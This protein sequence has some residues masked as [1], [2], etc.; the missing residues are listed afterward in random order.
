MV[1]RSD[2]Y[3]RPLGRR[4]FLGAAAAVL[5]AACAPQRGA[6]ALAPLAA[7]PAANE[8]PD[9]FWRATPEV[10]EAYRYALANRDV[11]QY[12]PCFCGCVAAGHRSNYDCYV[13]EARADGTVLL[14][15]MSFG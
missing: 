5:V 3:G 8:W 9:L 13:R 4:A 1:T 11:L 6:G 2:A 7:R 12:M 10:Q 14:D 15:G